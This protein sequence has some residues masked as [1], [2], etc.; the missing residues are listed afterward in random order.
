MNKQDVLREC[1]IA[2]DEVILR[3]REVREK[4]ALLAISLEVKEQ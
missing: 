2:L 3:L 1:L 4:L